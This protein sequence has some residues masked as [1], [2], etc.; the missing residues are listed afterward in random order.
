MVQQM[1]SH[2]PAVLALLSRLF[3]REFQTLYANIREKITTYFRKWMDKDLCVYRPDIV[4]GTVGV[5]IPVLSSRPAVIVMQLEE[6]IATLVK[7]YKVNS[8]IKEESDDDFKLDNGFSEDEDDFQFVNERPSIFKRETFHNKGD[9][10][11][12]VD[13]QLKQLQQLV[14]ELKT[15]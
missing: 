7:N 15:F 14:A 5:Q 2:M 1:L 11:S 8:T 13:A 4:E 6:D 12:D 10:S 3:S 9:G